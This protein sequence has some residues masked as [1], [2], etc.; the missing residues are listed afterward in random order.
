MDS[1]QV[2]VDENEIYDA[3]NIDIL[4]RKAALYSQTGNNDSLVYY[5]HQALAMATDQQNLHAQAV[6]HNELGYYFERLPDFDSA[7]YH[8]DKAIEIWK[9]ISAYRYLAAFSSTSQDY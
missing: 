3:V 1:A 4:D 8:Y 9:D 6:S 7:Y 5:S 2:I